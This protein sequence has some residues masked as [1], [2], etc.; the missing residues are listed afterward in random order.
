MTYALVDDDLFVCR[1]IGVRG[2]ANTERFRSMLSPLQKFASGLP[3]STSPTPTTEEVS[4]STKTVNTAS[5]ASPTSTNPMC[6]T[7]TPPS[8]DI[9]WWVHLI[10]SAVAL[11]L[12]VSICWWKKSK[13]TSFKKTHPR[14][15]EAKNNLAMIDDSRV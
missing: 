6:T 8:S 15:T 14:K 10:Y 12:I 11:L 7:D 3:S 13:Q 4:G 2:I 9:P 1:Y 5:T